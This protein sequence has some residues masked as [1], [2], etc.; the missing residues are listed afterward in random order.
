MNELLSG[1]GLAACIAGTFYL[2][3]KLSIAGFDALAA[4][5]GCKCR[6]AKVLYLKPPRK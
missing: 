1:V 5:K 3:V 4:R 2:A 6:T